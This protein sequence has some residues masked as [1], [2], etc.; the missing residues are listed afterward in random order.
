MMEEGI[1]QAFYRESNRARA[2]ARLSSRI[3]QPFR[4]TC[5]TCRSRLKI[6]S[7]DVIGQIHACPKCG[8]M[9]Q[10]VPPVGWDPNAVAVELPSAANEAALTLSTT[11]SVIFP[12][13]AMD[14][15]AAVT[16]GLDTPAVEAPVE[17]A[18]S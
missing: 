15:L 1:K 18:T 16:A 6:R 11:A 5:E 3:V 9:V 17:T 2:A 14:D 12:A 4:I 13:A 8:S 10:I 7:A